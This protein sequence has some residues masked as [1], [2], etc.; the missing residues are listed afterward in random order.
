VDIEPGDSARK[1]Y[2]AVIDIGTT[3]LVGYLIDLTTGT[4]LAE[5]GRP[6]GQSAW[7]ADLMA[8]VLAATPRARGGEDARDQLTRAVRRDIDMLL[9]SLLRQIRARKR[10]LLSLVFVG[11]SVMHHLFLGIPV[12]SLGI[13][14]YVPVIEEDVAFRPRDL[15]LRLPSSARAHF[16]PLLTGFVGADA[17]GVALA[18]G[19]DHPCREKAELALDLGTNVELLLG[20]PDGVIWC[21]STPAGPAFEGGEIRSGMLFGP[22][23]ISAMDVEGEKFRFR[24]IDG[25][26]PVGICGTGL[27]DVVAG[28]LDLGVIEPSGR[29]RT[30]EELARD[31]SDELCCRIFEEDGRRG[32]LL[33]ES[34][35]PT[36]A[37]R[38]VLD[39]WD[40][41]KLQAAK[42]AVRAA[43]DLLLQ[44]AGIAWEDVGAIHLAGAFGTHL[45]PERAARIGLLPPLPLDRVRVVNN[46]AASGARL[47]L[48]S[49]ADLKRA[50][51]LKKRTRYVELAGRT[52]FQ[53]AFFEAL[54]FPE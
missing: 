45:L 15:G 1:S 14:P 32:F 35:N 13:A 25:L 53:D 48:L 12:E 19:L 34:E 5:A 22:G 11:N 6:N 43:G 8:R 51:D 16:L 21:A 37:R 27:V 9:T 36:L 28:L 50:S 40:V 2:G 38:I 33:A 30:A 44:T 10:H 4:L 26:A 42:A 49:R 3:N 54:P 20:M 18:V 31:K 24:T 41:R 17:V 39:Q 52:K 47:A 29:V 7:G 46:A 23:A